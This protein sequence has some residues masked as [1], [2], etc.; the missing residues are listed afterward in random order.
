MHSKFCCAT[1]FIKC[2]VC[3]YVCVYSMY[4]WGQDQACI[5][6]I[7]CMPGAEI[8]CVLCVLCVCLVPRSGMYICVLHQCLVLRSGGPSGIGVTNGCVPLCGYQKL[9]LG[10]VQDKCSQF[11]MGLLS[12]IM[13][14]GFSPHFNQQV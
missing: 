12:I 7:A 10:P 9:N 8:R 13:L 11:Y 14:A 6:C 1:F 5:V 3:I 2:L 4:A